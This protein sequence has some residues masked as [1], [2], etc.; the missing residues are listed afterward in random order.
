MLLDLAHSAR[1]VCA[2]LLCC[3]RRKWTCFDHWISF[4]GD[5]KAEG[6]K[7]T[8]ADV[9]SVVAQTGYYEGLISLLVSRPREHHPQPQQVQ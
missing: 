5:H 2:G 1:G 8:Q 4:A 6:W 9:K 7:T 3:S